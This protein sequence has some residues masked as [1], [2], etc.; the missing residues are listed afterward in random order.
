MPSISE[1]AAA[2]QFQNL[3]QSSLKRYLKTQES[4]RE[5]FLSQNVDLDYICDSLSSLGITKKTFM[6]PPSSPHNPPIL[7]TNR[8]VIVL[9]I[10]RKKQSRSKK[11]C[12]LWLSQLGALPD[13]KISHA[14]DSLIKTYHNKLKNSHR[15]YKPSLMEY[16]TCVPRMFLKYQT[17]TLLLLILIQHVQLSSHLKM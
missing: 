1:A 4:N 17:R 3:V 2:T 15:E 13:S 8:V 16:F 14:V 6:I 10:Y 5:Q 7:I 11:M 9:E 12:I